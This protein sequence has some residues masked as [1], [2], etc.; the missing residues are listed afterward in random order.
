MYSEETPLNS[1]SVKKTI[2]QPYKAGSPKSNMDMHVGVGVSSLGKCLF[3][4][5]VPMTR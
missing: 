1:C 3:T 5:R 2:N 4:S